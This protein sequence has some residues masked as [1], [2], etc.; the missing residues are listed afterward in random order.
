MDIAWLSSPWDAPVFISIGTMDSMQGKVSDSREHCHIVRRP[1]Q[2]ELADQTDRLWG[3]LW[4]DSV[5][6]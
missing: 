6:E 5:K 2:L 1:R 3:L 4:M